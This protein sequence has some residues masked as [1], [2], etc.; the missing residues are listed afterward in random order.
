[1]RFLDGGSVGISFHP[2]N[3]VVALDGRHLWG[4]SE[5][6]KSSIDATSSLVVVSAVDAMKRLEK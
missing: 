6:G 2:E 3:L 1:M 5:S 4:S